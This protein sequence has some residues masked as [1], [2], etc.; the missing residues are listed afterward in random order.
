[1]DDYD[2]LSRYRSFYIKEMLI[3][4][5]LIAGL[6]GV[7]RLVYWQ[8]Y[9]FTRLGISAVLRDKHG[10][11][12]YLHLSTTQYLP[13]IVGK[14]DCSRVQTL[15][16]YGAELDSSVALT[17]QFPRLK[18]LYLNATNLDD[19]LA[20]QITGVSATTVYAG[21]TDLTRKGVEALLQSNHIH[22]IDVRNTVITPEDAQELA[23]QY[24]VKIKLGPEYPEDYYLPKSKP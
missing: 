3:G 18:V 7:L 24:D 9:E 17:D 2:S 12:E 15:R 1:M 11:I 14:F 10:R 8:K 13:A 21:E 5:A 6:F 16:L 23:N 20:R 19:A 22:V 4:V